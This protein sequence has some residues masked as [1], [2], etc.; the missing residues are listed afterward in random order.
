MYVKLQELELTKIISLLVPQ[1][2]E[3]CSFLRIYHR[4][5]PQYDDFQMADSLLP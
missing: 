3:A 5:W 4:E 1:L 2:S